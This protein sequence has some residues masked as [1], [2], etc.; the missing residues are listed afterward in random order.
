MGETVVWF[1]MLTSKTVKVETITDKNNY[2]I[3]KNYRACK[4]LI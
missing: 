2:C 4:K 3:G 1:H